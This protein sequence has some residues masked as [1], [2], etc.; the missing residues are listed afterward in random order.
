[1]AHW[2][3]RKLLECQVVLVAVC[4]SQWAQFHR[5]QRIITVVM[6]IQV[7]TESQSAF[8]SAAIIGCFSKENEHWLGPAAWYSAFV[9]SLF[10]ILLSSFQAFIFSTIKLASGRRSLA[11]ELLMIA[12]VRQITDQVAGN[13][14]GKGDG[15]LNKQPRRQVKIR[16]NM[17]LTWQAPV[18]LMDYAIACSPQA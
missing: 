7:L 13:N 8:L 12:R 3:E 5:C 16:W 14:G 11:K 17:A 15:E 18:M 10:A 2:R 1:M 4:S 6:V 9:M